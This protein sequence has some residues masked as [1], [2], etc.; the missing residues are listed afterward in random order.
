VEERALS[1]L[2]RQFSSKRGKLDLFCAGPL[3][4][5]R[6]S[7]HGDGEFAT[8]ILAAFQSIVDRGEKAEMFL[9]MG[10]MVNYDS[11][12]RTRLTSHFVRHRSQVASLHVFTRSRIVSM[13]VSVANLALGRLI[14]GH[15]DMAGFNDALDSI[16]RKTRTVGIS[17][18][19]LSLS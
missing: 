19:L 11:T 17:S 18:N 5:L 12:L 14:T 10:R 13:G 3:L 15:A 7:D 4:V 16:A 1:S 2:G 6:F 9:D 8:E